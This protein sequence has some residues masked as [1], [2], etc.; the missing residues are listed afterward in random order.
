MKKMFALN[1]IWSYFSGYAQDGHGV[2][3]LSFGRFMT[4]LFLYAGAFVTLATDSFFQDNGI[5]VYRQGIITIFFAFVVTASLNWEMLLFGRASGG[6]MFLQ[7]LQIPPLTLLLARLTAFPST[8]SHQPLIKK[9]FQFLQ[10]TDK[11][12]FNLTS[13]IPDW[14]TDLFSNWRISLCFILVL[15]ILS[16]RSVRLKLGMLISVFAVLIASA[17]A[18]RP[19]ICLIGGFILL[20][21]GYTFQFCRYDRVIFFENAVRRIARSGTCDSMQTSVLL[22]ILSVFYESG[23]VSRQQLLQLV[24]SVYAENH[25]LSGNDLQL[26]TGEIVRRMVYQY[27]LAKVISTGEGEF[28]IPNSR[29]F[30]YDNLLGMA[31]VAPRIVLTLVFGILWILIPV[32]LVPD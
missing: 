26:I 13:M 2:T 6:N 3:S 30:R 12:L 27:D 31:A 18:N 20:A 23:R 28:L 24:Q 16:F 19:S 5:F 10:D 25:P 32:D 4:V 1:R 7:F 8:P 9:L 11:E 14:L 15:L 29:L 17:A 21:A 22:S